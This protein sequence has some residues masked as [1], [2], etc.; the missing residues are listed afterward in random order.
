MPVLFYYTKLVP[1][2]LLDLIDGRG[3]KDKGKLTLERVYQLELD[4][5]AI[6]KLIL[7]EHPELEC[8]VQLK[9]LAEKYQFFS[10]DLKIRDCQDKL[11]AIVDA[12]DDYCRTI[13]DFR[14]ENNL[15]PYY[16]FT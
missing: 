2:V 1:K 3:K 4:T 7:K 15:E 9:D 11:R 10:R 14:K 16:V 13:Y 5:E 8:L 12:E 6:G